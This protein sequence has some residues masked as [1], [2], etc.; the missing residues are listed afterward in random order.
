[1]EVIKFEDIL[2]Q[3]AA[4]RI[5][6]IEEESKE[7]DDSDNNSDN[8]LAESSKKQKSCIPRGRPKSGRVWK[9]RKS[10]YVNLCLK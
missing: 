8:S 7:E 1:M 2:T 10:R 9:Q 3:T 6:S 5:E 4:S